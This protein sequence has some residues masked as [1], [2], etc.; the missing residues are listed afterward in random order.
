M[1][2]IYDPY[3]PLGILLL[4]ALGLGVAIL[5]LNGILG[6]KRTSKEK[7]TPFECGNEPA[8]NPRQR[9]DVKFYLTA[10]FFIV[11]DVEVVFLF[12][13]AV[14]YREQLSAGNGWFFFAEMV[15][16]LGVLTVGLAY[17]WKRGALDWE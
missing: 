13:W 1:N 2:P 12:P 4:L 11:F 3:L 14:L 6:P 10:L 16:F 15:F 9:F 17:V 8:S 7:S 5:F